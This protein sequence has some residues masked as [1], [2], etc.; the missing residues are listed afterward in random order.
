MADNDLEILLP[1]ITLQLQGKPVTVRE[2]SF[3]QGLR[4]DA[5][6]KPFFDDL[7]R[8]FLEGDPLKDSDRAELILDELQAL[9]T[10]LLALSTGESAEW[11]EGLGDLDGQTLL[12]TWWTVNRDFFVRRLAKQQAARR[13]KEKLTGE[14]SSPA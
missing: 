10:Q 6:A 1:D 4:V 5:M 14:R 12:M 13:A 3:V 8:I 2:Y 7:S 11:V 9:M